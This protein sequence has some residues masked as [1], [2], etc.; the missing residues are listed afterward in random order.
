MGIG[1]IF[2][3]SFLRMLRK[4]AIDV[5]CLDGGYPLHAVVAHALL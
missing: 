4:Y 3:V 5:G 2:F 1:I